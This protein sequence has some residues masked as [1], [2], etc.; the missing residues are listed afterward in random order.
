MNANGVHL[1]EASLR[2]SRQTRRHCASKAERGCQSKRIYAGPGAARKPLVKIATGGNR[3][4][5][6]GLRYCA[7]P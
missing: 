1:V 7:C 6:L 2:D 3:I 5:E 4:C